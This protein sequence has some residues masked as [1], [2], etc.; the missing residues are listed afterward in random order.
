MIRKA[1]INDIKRIQN[2]I[3]GYAEEGLMLPRSLGE[4]CENVRDFFVYEENKE[5]L[6]CAALHI[7]WEKLAEI[8]SL[9]VDSRYKKKG[10]GKQLLAACLNEAGDLQIKEI[11][12][13]TYEVDF[14]NKR[15]FKE[16][17]KS[18]LPHKIWGECLDCVKFPSCEEQ[19]LILTL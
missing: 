6:G 13:L 8:K 17:D 19:A 5:I 18:K 15:G 10:I 11:F 7:V 12:V 14:F 4:L 2:L 1:N 9:A 16:L 3:N